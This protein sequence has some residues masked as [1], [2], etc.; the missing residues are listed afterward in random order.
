MID[1]H[2][3]LDHEPLY[4]NLS[5]VVN[6]AENNGVK[7][8]LTISTNLESFDRI[9]LIISKFKNIFGTF[10][11]HPHETK[12]HSNINKEKII[13]IQKKYNKIIGI[14]ETGLDYY[15]NNSDKVIQK[16]LF[17]EHIK[18]SL[19]LNLPIIVHSRKAEDD[20]FKILNEY[21]IGSISSSLNDLANQT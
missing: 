4:E 16:K 15:Y 10:G 1:S 6:R 21:S 17:I 11:I 8:M 3:H 5:D 9:K 19:E 2:C 20:T 13:S 18:A 7:L 12:I 14:G